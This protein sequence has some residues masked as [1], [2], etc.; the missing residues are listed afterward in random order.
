MGFT[1]EGLADTASDSQEHSSGV[2][3]SASEPESGCMDD[4]ARGTGGPVR[5]VLEN[6]CWYVHMTC[7]N[8]RLSQ[9][10]ALLMQ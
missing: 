9:L 10:E 2:A 6:T 8:L 1:S 4:T 5:K 3:A 7:S